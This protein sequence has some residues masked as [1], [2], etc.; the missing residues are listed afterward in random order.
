MRFLLVLALTL[1]L[2]R[3]AAASAPPAN[4]R[5][6]DAIIQRALALWNV[7]GVAVAVVRGD[8]VV[9]LKGHGVREVGNKAPLTPD[10]LFPIASCTKAFVTA[11]LAMLVA[12]GKLD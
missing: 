9:Y 11:A 6:L 7:P 4:T 12:E 8:E 5:E 3:P 10:S 1:A 2:A